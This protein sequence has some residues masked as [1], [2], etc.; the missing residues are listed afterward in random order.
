MNVFVSL[1]L[2]Q[3]DN[4][5]EAIICIQEGFEMK[6]YDKYRIGYFVPPVNEYDWVKKEMV[7][8]GSP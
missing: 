5:K 2:D 4:R 8:R 1:R 7:Q 6:N 3:M